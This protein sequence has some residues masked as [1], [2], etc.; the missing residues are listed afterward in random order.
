MLLKVK[1]WKYRKNYLDVENFEWFI[2]NQVF[3]PSYDLAPP[4]PPPPSPDSKLSLLLSLPVCRWSSWWRWWG[5]SQIIRR[6]ES[7]VL[8]E[9]FNARGPHTFASAKNY[10]KCRVYKNTCTRLQNDDDDT[11]HLVLPLI[12][13]FEGEGPLRK[14]EIII[15]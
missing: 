3:S 10:C 15:H 4:P 7:L 6:R 2:E 13:L 8:H 9:S 5:R 12:H 11:K 1:E 14:A